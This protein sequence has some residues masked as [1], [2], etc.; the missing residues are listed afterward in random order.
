M[1]ENN[2]EE[3]LQLKNDFAVFYCEFI[4]GNHMNNI[5]IFESSYDIRNL[6]SPLIKFSGKYDNISI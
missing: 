5:F 2:V 4:L 6:Y 3:I 1:E